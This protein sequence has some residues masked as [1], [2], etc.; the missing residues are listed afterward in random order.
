MIEISK[1]IV[2][3]LILQGAILSLIA[4]IGVI[5]LPDVYTR[6]HAASK[7]A[8]LGVI[9]IL[10]GLFLH[11]ILID[12]HAN[13]RVLLGIIFVFVTA[14]VAG[15]LISRAAYN[16]GVPLWNKSV[17]DDLAKVRSKQKSR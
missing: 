17:Q 14:P 11:Y 2:G 7:S 13:S 16:T 10:L 3:Y 4:A 6:N 12:H 5:R 8:T 15:H 1:F 9:S